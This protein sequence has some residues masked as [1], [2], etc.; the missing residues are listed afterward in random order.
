MAYQLRQSAMGM[1]FSALLGVGLLLTAPAS[2]MTVLDEA[3]VVV[4]VSLDADG[5]MAP[6]REA[7]MSDGLSRA[8]TIVMLLGSLVFSA[9]LLG[10]KVD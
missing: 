6:A 1:R 5:A 3:P 2:A 8:E 9:V 4:A 10:R 7:A